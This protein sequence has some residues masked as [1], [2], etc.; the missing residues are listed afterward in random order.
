MRILV[1]AGASGIGRAIAERFLVEGAEAAICDVDPEAVADFARAHPGTI[2]EVADVTSETG[3]ESFLSRS[4]RPGTA[5][6]SFAPMRAP[7]ARQ[8]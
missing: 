8:A 3:M 7:A 1:T 2:A 4:R 5:S 6:M